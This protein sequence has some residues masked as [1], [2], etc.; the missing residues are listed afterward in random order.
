MTDSAVGCLDVE[1]AH[2][3]RLVKHS[4]IL[5]SFAAAR[6]LSLISNVVRAN[7]DSTSSVN[8]NNTVDRLDLR[9]RRI[10]LQLDVKAR[11]ST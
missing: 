8:E 1:T 2:I 7:G 9:P 5:S 6:R 3:T 11:P 10:L 4:V